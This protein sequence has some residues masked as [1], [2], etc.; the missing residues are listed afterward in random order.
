MKAE[1]GARALPLEERVDRS[2]RAEGD[3][4]KVR[5]LVERLQREEEDGEIE[6]AAGDRGIVIAVIE[7]AAG[8]NP[9]EPEGDGD[10]LIGMRGIE[11][12]PGQKRRGEEIDRGEGVR[13]GE[14]SEYVHPECQGKIAEIDGGLVEIDAG[15]KVEVQAAQRIKRRD[16]QDLREARADRVDQRRRAAVRPPQ[17]VRQP[18]ATALPRE[19]VEHGKVVLPAVVVD[20]LAEIGE[21]EQCP[22]RRHAQYEPRRAWSHRRPILPGLRAVNATV[23]VLPKS[24]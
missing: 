20:E 10:D 3:E 24:D 18:A 17:P 12:E 8:E 21:V 11:A 23:A 5:V 19:A 14:A 13:Q 9:G 1:G 4:R 22:E 6:I 16:A 2:C 15:E 7:N